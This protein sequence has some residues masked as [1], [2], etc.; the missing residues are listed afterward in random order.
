MDIQTN[1]LQTE[2][3]QEIAFDNYRCGYEKV[4][5]LAHGF[6]NNKD[7]YLFKKI[8]QKFAEHYDVISFD[9]RGHGKSSGL[10]TWTS[11]EPKDL[12]AVLNYAKG[13][14][15]LRIGVVG[16]SLGAAVTLIEAG[17]NDLIDSIIAVSAPYDFGMINFHFWEREM[18]EDLKLNL[19]M[20]GKGKFVRPGNPFLKKINPIDTVD[21][22]F[23]V[24]VCF[25]HGAKDWLIK[26]EHSEKLFNKANDP[27]R[28]LIIENA[29]H[30]EKIF[31]DKPG[32]FIEECIQWFNQTLA[33]GQK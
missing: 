5:I 19:G 28:L 25:I 1:T 16:F 17:R 27:K 3:G 21:N 30:A 14:G 33:Q 24:P 15:Y 22:S 29:G 4:I 8:A 32:E 31:D 6:Y 23:L 20:K 11:N 18:L 7:A 13:Q 9:F 10:F 12:E 26:K 2:D